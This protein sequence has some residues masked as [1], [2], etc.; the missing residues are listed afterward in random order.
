M[1]IDADLGNVDLET[2]KKVSDY[3]IEINTDLGKNQI[4]GK[5]VSSEY[6]SKGTEGTIKIDCSLG[7]V[8]IYTK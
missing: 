5:S 1:D 3:S 4:D 6:E 7:N 8:N 2:I